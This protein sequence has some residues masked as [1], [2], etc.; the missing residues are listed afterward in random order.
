MTNT[1]KVNQALATQNQPLPLQQLIEKSAKELGKALPEHMRPERL[2]R[3][4]L[5]CIRQVPDLAKCTP[6]SFMGALFVSAQMGIEPIG[7]RAYILPFRNS[8]KKPDGSWST[9]TEAQ[10]VMGYRGLAELFYRHEKAVQLAWGIVKA[11]DEFEYEYGTEAK[12]RHKPAMTERGET[13]G[14]YVIA[15]L[16]GGA[17]PFMYMS[18][19]DCM[20]HGK[21]HSKTY[22][23]KTGQFYAASPWATNPDAMCLKT[24]LIQLSKLLPLSIELQ[25]AIQ[26]DESSR[27]YRAG[28][29]DALDLPASSWEEAP[30]APEKPAPTANPKHEETTNASQPMPQDSEWLESPQ[31]A[32]KQANQPI[33]RICRGCLN[34]VS[35]AESKFSRSRYGKVLCRA[36]QKGA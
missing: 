21:K 6:N 30:E 2:V 5:T 29:D 4:A 28:I 35:E 3:I 19:E 27:E 1:E 8:K 15:E 25:R 32:L 10:F 7:G 20:E 9:V 22:D 24:V 26:A 31:E 23:K 12:L 14:Y 11:G 13:I 16:A 34:E 17:K 36:C 18:L 33:D